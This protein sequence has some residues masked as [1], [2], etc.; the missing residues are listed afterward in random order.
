MP[1]YLQA[2]AGRLGRG[3]GV[4]PRRRVAQQLMAQGVNTSPT[5][6]GGGL[7]RLG[8]ALAAA[9]MMRQSQ[10]QEADAMKWLTAKDPRTRPPTEAEAYAA[11]PELGEL[12]RASDVQWG[13]GQGQVNPDAPVTDGIDW[14]SLGVR[15][16]SQTMADFTRDKEDHVAGLTREDP[17][18]IKVPTE[19]QIEANTEAEIARIQKEYDDPKSPFYTG[20]DGERTPIPSPTPTTRDY[21][22]E[23]ASGMKAYQGAEANQISDPRTRMEWLRESARGMEGNPFV[24]RMLQNLMFAEMQRDISQEDIKS[25]RAFTKSEREAGEKFK[26]GE[27]ELDRKSREKTA[28]EKAVGLDPSNVREWQYY[29]KLKPDQQEAYLTMKRADKSFNIGG[30]VITPSQTDPQNLKGKTATTLKPSEE[31]PYIQEVE[32]I[33]QESKLGAKRT[34]DLI[35]MQPKA[36]SA[37]GSFQQKTEFM[38]DN[39]KNAIANISGW[40]TKYGATLSGWPGSQAQALGTIL[41]TI[42]A[43]VGFQALQ[44]MRAN[45]PTGGALGQVSERELAYLQ[46]TLG[47]LAQTQDGEIL[48]KKLKAMLVQVEGMDK[49]LQEAYDM[50][51]AP[52]QGKTPVVPPVTNNRRKEDDP[53]DL[54]L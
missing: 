29:S 8:K 1:N 24:S 20:R 12:E 53:M 3:M 35:R 30:S 11:S 4:D 49:R 52:L 17:S 45:S 43:N 23:L 13:S 39:V 54:G 42:K 2:M 41:Q 16:Q 33:K 37:L 14:G 15:D 38:K 47:D 9:Y 28:L 40:S 34:D 6:L 46:A 44:E 27:S 25:N 51:F 31:E 32:D 26:A 50:T 48:T 36:T 5:T 21:A 22:Q 7:G 18:I 19:E 10:D